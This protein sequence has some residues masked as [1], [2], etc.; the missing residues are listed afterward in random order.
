MIKQT[1]L[2]THIIESKSKPLVSIFHILSTDY[3]QVVYHL[4]ADDLL[5]NYSI[6]VMRLRDK[7]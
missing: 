4:R 2:H 7:N 5:M 1:E 3:S 6:G